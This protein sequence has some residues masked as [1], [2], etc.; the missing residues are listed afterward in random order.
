MRTRRLEACA[1]RRGRASAKTLARPIS[2]RNVLGITLKIRASPQPSEWAGRQSGGYPFP[3]TERPIDLARDPRHDH[4]P[5]GTSAH[6]I[7]GAQLAAGRAGARLDSPKPAGPADSDTDELVI[8]IAGSRCNFTSWAREHPG[9]AS[10][11]RR[12]HGKDATAAF[13]G[14]HH[15]KEAVALLQ[16]FLVPAVQASVQASVQATHLAQPTV[17]GVELRSKLP[18]EEDRRPPVHKILGVLALLHFLARAPTGGFAA[19]GNIGFAAVLPHGALSASSLR[20]HVPKE[21]IASKPMVW[22]E[23]RAHNI[24]HRDARLR[25]S[26]ALLMTLVR[27]GIIS[28]ARYHLLYAGSLVLTFV[29]IVRDVLLF[30]VPDALLILP[31]AACPFALRRRGV[32]RCYGYLFWRPGSSHTALSPSLARQVNLSLRGRCARSVICSD[33][34]IPTSGCFRG[35]YRPRPPYI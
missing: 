18:T 17:E 6:A 22:Q 31:L 14:A 4:K 8:I 34:N 15:S 24:V 12:Q 13:E 28:A 9:G 30:G 11:L 27:K 29:P 10:V 1:A 33:A 2:M 16:R 32:S 20:F 19:T 23:F 5:P 7:A 26:A 3:S 21:S 25:N 35:A